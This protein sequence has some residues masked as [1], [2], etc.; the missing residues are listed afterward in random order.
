MRSSLSTIEEFLDTMVTNAKRSNMGRG[1]SS[2]SLSVLSSNA[3]TNDLS[4]SSKFSIAETKKEISFSIV[5]GSVNKNII[6]YII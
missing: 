3:K 2:S 4:K 6:F 1:S 5:M